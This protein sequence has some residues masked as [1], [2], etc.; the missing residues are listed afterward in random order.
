MNNIVN[1]FGGYDYNGEVK[2][3]N[4][5]AKNKL[6]GITEIRKYN[7]EEVNFAWKFINENGEKSYKKL[8]K[9]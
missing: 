5:W 6:G 3:H 8:Q 2:F 4:F 7:Q 9:D 1:E